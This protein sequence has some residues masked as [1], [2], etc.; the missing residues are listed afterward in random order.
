MDFAVPVIGFE[1]LLMGVV[2]A[3]LLARMDFEDPRMD[4]EDLLLDFEYLLTNLTEASPLVKAS[5]TP[6]LSR[7]RRWVR[8][9]A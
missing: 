5:A 4:C 9:R 1:V 2:R 7:S 6:R 3:L 8:S